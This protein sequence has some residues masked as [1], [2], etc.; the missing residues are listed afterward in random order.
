MDGGPHRNLCAGARVQP[1]AEWGLFTMSAQRQAWLG[2]ASRLLATP[3][4]PVHIRDVI[5]DAAHGTRVLVLALLRAECVGLHDAFQGCLDL[6]GVVA[7]EGVEREA[8]RS[9]I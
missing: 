3:A 6:H 4:H 5:C 2:V 9:A 1:D 7:L 8:H